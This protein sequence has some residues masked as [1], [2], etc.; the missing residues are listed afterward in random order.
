MDFYSILISILLWSPPGKWVPLVQTVEGGSKNSNFLTSAQWPLIHVLLK[1]AAI[2]SDTALFDYMVFCRE[3][4]DELTRAHPYLQL[5]DVLSSHKG[6]EKV[7]HCK[8]LPSLPHRSTK[9]RNIFL[10]RHS[11]WKSKCGVENIVR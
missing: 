9:T 11:A 2:I 4:W 3:G 5:S 7:Y 6:A 10:H 1:H 8:G